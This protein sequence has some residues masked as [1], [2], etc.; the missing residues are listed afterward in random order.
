MSW[1][2]AQIGRSS[3][4]STAGAAG[5]RGGGSAAACDGAL[6]LA[7]SKSWSTV[8]GRSCDAGGRGRTGGATGGTALLAVPADV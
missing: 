3:C 7:S 4:D 1:Q 6:L 8:T 2:I 5:G